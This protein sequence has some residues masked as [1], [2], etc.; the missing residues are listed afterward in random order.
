MRRHRQ[1]HIARGSPLVPSE[2]RSDNKRSGPASDRNRH[3]KPRQ[4]ADCFEIQRPQILP[5]ALPRKFGSD[6]P[7]ALPMAVAMMAIG[8]TASRNMRAYQPASCREKNATIMSV[9]TETLR[10]F[11][12]DTA[13]DTPACCR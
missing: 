3:S 11:I 8:A 5:L 13:V 7:E 4:A 6:G 1:K 10:V 2:Q 9:F 12:K